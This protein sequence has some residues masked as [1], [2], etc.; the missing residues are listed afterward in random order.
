M[1][2]IS[3]LAKECLSVENILKYIDD[4]S[5]YSYYIGCE[6]ELNTRYSSPL[7]EGDDN[8]SFTLFKGRQ[9]RIYFKD[10]ATTYKG[11]V[12]EFVRILMGKGKPKDIPFEQVLQRIDNDF[13]LG[14]YVENSQPTK[15]DLK[16]QLATIPV[17]EK[18][19]IQVTSKKKPTKQYL[20]FWSKYDITKSTLDY[21]K[22]SQAEVIHYSSKQGSHKFQIYPKELCIAYPIAARY[23]LY[24]PY[25]DKKKKFQNDL[26]ANWVKGFMQLKYVNDFCIITKANKEINFFREHFDWDT[27]AGKS[28]NTMIPDHMMKK[29]FTSYKKVFI[30]LDSDVPGINAQAKYIEKYPNLIPII[31]PSY[32]TQKDVTDRYVYMKGLGMQQA[33]IEEIKK[34]IL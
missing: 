16:R 8:P 15:L 2:V 23:E 11:D 4:Y 30:W 7:R 29:L 9:D 33:A 34:L 5:I 12:F 28:E 10:H 14:L 19:S 1:C 3:D 24:W 27:V 17:K 26:P 21:N 13:Q 18:Y 20:D 32:V 31:Y 22:V 25:E 6:L